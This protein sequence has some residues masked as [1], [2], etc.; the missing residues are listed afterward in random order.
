MFIDVVVVGLRNIK[1]SVYT[2]VYVTPFFILVRLI[3][4]DR[5]NRS[6]GKIKYQN[7][8]EKH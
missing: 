4:S 2:V 3:D 5:T 1:R 6:L 8:I 7:I